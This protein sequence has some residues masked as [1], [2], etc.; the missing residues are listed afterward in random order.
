M[1]GQVLN[2]RYKLI[3]VLGAGGFGQTFVA[4]DTQRA[5][6]PEC[7]VKQL[8]PASQDPQFLKVA[9][10]LFDT[11]VF[12]LKRLGEHNRIPELL[13]SF[14]DADEFYLVQE[15]I[16]GEILSDEIQR[17]GKLSEPDVIDLLRETLTI[18][19]FV[20]ENH[21][22]HRD[23]K[24]DNL[25]RRQ[26]DRKLCLIDFG[27]VKEIRTQL[28]SGEMTSLTVGIGTQGYTPSE[29][30]AGKPR[31]SSDLFALGMT[32]IYALTG[33]TPTDLP[34][35][36]ISLDLKWE[37]FADVSPGLAILLK[38]MVRHYFYQ[39]YQSAD[40]VLKD[41]D[42]LDELE[43]EAV[44]AFPQTF[45][46]QPTVWQPSRKES[47][48]A[49]AIAT[50]AASALT[51]V[52]RQVGGWM[53]LELATHD[54][55]VSHRRDAGPDPRLLVVGITENDYSNEQ[56]TI[57]S[58]A[59]LASV[60]DTLQA[61]NPA[62]IGLDL[63]RDVPQPP[64]TEALLDQ[65]NQPNVVAITKVGTGDD[66]IPPP[67]NVPPE[68]VGFNDFVIDRDNKLRRNLLFVPAL[69]DESAILSSFGLQVALAYLEDQHD[70][71]A[72]ASEQNEE[73]MQIGPATFVPLG[74]NFGAY[75]NADAGGYQVFLDYRA[76]QPAAQQISVAELLA[77]EFEPEWIADNI[78]LIGTAAY[79]TTDKFFTPY[80]LLGGDN[81]EMYGVEVHA[82]MVSQVLTAVLDG[83]P[84]AWSWSEGAEIA[85]IVLCAAGG[86]MLTWRVR[87]SGLL[88]VDLLVGSAG[89]VGVS[90]AFFLV[91]AW[92]PAIAPTS[93]F[94]VAGIG[95]LAYRRYRQRQLES[96]WYGSRM[97]G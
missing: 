62:V 64:G 86:S 28:V 67:P 78:V 61:H 32:A 79:T 90:V 40:E 43:E 54:W 63:H 73:Y 83:R 92:V 31:Y 13:D 21:V 76:P 69:E 72:E 51:L 74:P 10:R 81:Y 9:R 70:I 20:H 91:N 50:L 17:V 85:W 96:K 71:V 29:Q 49:V 5:G 8:R 82:Q 89:I 2:H 15:F 24:P 33:R 41:L 95:L 27:A 35:D 34:E 6:D 60:I 80:S 88:T 37:P 65:L 58:D 57:L 16:D 53:P 19:K 14:E 30:L 84:L 66:S 36:A 44:A 97:A 45:L 55:L 22:V 87:R 68:Q 42:R 93:S 11:E 25:I 7:V 3:R 59:T 18:L 52:I 1:L 94:L 38:K 56:R 46:P 77:G 12:T 47:L 23:L 75:Q 4:I 48:W 26:C 39:R